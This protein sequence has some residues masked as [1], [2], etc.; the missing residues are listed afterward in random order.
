MAGTA[1]RTARVSRVIWSPQEAVSKL[2]ARRTETAC[3]AAPLGRE[4]QKTQ[5]PIA[6][7]RVWNYM[8]RVSGRKVVRLTRGDLAG[9]HG[10]PSLQSEGMGCQKSAE[11]I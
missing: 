11:A 8:R 2:L 6:I 1:S 7:R 9:G 3:E 4:G 5:S 10:L